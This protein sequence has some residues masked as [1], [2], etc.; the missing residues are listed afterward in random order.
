MH[1]FPECHKTLLTQITEWS[2]EP[3]IPPATAECPNQNDKEWV[4]GCTVNGCGNTQMCTHTEGST[5]ITNT[6]ST[7]HTVSPTT[8]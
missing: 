4:A 8:P 2:F 5:T 6:Y 1:L 7:I 3:N